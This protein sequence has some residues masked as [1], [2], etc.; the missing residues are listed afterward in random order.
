MLLVRLVPFTLAAATLALSACDSL[1]PSN[2]LRYEPPAAPAAPEAASGWTDKPGWAFNKFAV[3]AAN[4]IATDVGYQVLKAGGAAIDAAVAVQMVL[5]LVEPQA[6]GIGGGAFLMHYDGKAVEAY[7][8]RETAPAAADEKMLLKPDGTPMALADAVVGGR[9]VGT[10]GTLRM[11]EMAH[12][13]HGRLPWRQL[14]EPAIVL[15]ERGFRVSPRLNA[16]LEAETSLRKDPVAAA[17][18][19]TAEGKPQPVGTLLRNSELAAVLR[20]IADKGAG[21]FYSGPIAEAIVAKVRGHAGNPGR[22]G[23]QDLAGYKALRRDA[24][25]S[26][27]Q[28]VRL[29][30][31]PPP[32]SG[33]IAI[34]QILGILDELPFTGAAAIDAAGLPT[35]DTLHQVTEASRLAFADRSMYVADPAFIGAP[36]G[37]WRSLISPVYLKQRAAL[38]GDESMK[39]ARPGMPSGAALAFAAQPEQV[40]HGSS[41]ISIV[42]A[43]GN[44]VAMTTTIEDAFGSRQMVKGF[45]LNN[46]LTDF[47]FAPADAAGTPIANRVQPGKRPR[48]NMSPTLVF[49]RNNS[50]LLMTAGSPGGALIIN[51]TA[52]TLLGSLAW[53][54]TVQ[55][56]INLPNFGSVNGPTLLEE[57]RFPSATIDSL[58]ARGHEVRE[59]PMQSGLQAIERTP[60]GWFGGADPRREGVVIGE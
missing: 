60:G 48:S 27:W 19:Y 32:S 47:S 1:G 38:V 51:F 41:Q 8:G 9:S 13:Q 46:E 33:H 12:Q 53:G 55:Q 28:E 43:R 2:M 26:Y 29:C 30:G 7:D 59:L 39:T 10:P 40:E 14:F 21:A 35:A 42:D 18:F 56:A 31:F 6:S 45:L 4:P 3:A 23:L 25:C 37:N 44:A 50:Q 17:Y 15:A 16:L 22:L 58:K 20:E 57:G 5:T 49:D 54:L 36:A 34:A 52:K 11:L 24:L